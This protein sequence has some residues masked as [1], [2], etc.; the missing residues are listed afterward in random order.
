[1][2]SVLI[3]EDEIMIAKGLSH[4]ITQNYPDFHVAGIAKNGLDGLKTALEL[5]PDL[6]FSDINMPGMNGLEMLSEIR[7]AGLAS[8]YVILSGY[9]DFEYARTAM[10]IGVKD[11]LLKP[12]RPDMLRP[13]MLSM[14]QQCQ[15]EIRILQTEYLQRN[16]KGVFAESSAQNPLTG[17][18]CILL[19][20]VSGPLCGNVYME[21]LSGLSSAVLSAAQ[22]KYLETQYGISMLPL[23]SRHLNEYLCALVIPRGHAPA[24]ESLT[25]DIRDHL[26]SDETYLSILLS[27]KITDGHNIHAISKAL[28]LYALFRTTFGSSGIYSCAALPDQK[29]SVSHEVK[30]LCSGIPAQPTSEALHDFIHTMRKFWESTSVTQFQLTTDLRYFINFL[31][32]DRENESAFYLDA[33]EIIVSC[34]SYDDLEST[35]QYESEQ[36]YEQKDPSSFHSQQSLAVQL[37]D[38]LDSNFTTQISYKILSDVFGHNEKYLSVV[39]KSEFGISPSKYIGELRLDMAKKLIQSNPNILL[40]DVAEMVGFTDVFYFSRTFKSHEGIPPKQ[41]AQQQRELLEGRE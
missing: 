3:V 1:M 41:Y 36:I 25:K 10:L 31:F 19:L 2:I 8:R 27:E 26:K 11:Y 28:Y 14:R 37:R 5:K 40:K 38:W 33:A 20:A 29:I 9:A 39:F 30:Q 13:I 16:L 7:K 23:H 6:I 35:L 34:R 18:D 15:T 24:L 32:H 21:S 4:L 22:L 12:I 17:C